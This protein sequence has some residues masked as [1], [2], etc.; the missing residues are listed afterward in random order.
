MLGSRPSDRRRTRRRCRA[1]LVLHRSVERQG[2]AHRRPAAG[3]RSSTRRPLGRRLGRHR[4]GR[5]TD[6]ARRSRHGRARPAQVLAAPVGID[7]DG[8]GRARSRTAPSPSSTSAGTRPAT[9]SRSGSRTRGSLD[10]PAEP[11]PRS[12]RRPAIS[13][14]RTAL[15]R[16]SP[17][18][19]GSRSPTAAWPGRPRPARA[20]RAAGSRSWP[21]PTSCRSGR[22]RSRRRRRRRPLTAPRL[23]R[24]RCAAD[25]AIGRSYGLRRLVRPRRLVVG[26]VLTAA[27]ALVALPGLAGSRAPNPLEPVPAVAFQPLTVPRT[28]AIDGFD[29]S[30]LDDAFVSAADGRRRDTTFD[31][32]PDVAADSRPRSP[33]GRRVTLPA[34][35]PAGRGVRVAQP[36]AG[37]PK[38]SCRR[39][40]LLR[41][42]HDRDAP[43]ARHGRHD[44][45]PAAAASTARRQRLRAAEDEPGRRPVPPGLLRICGCPS[46]SGTTQVTVSVY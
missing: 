33:P 34:R 41:Q 6:T 11:R 13:T 12:T 21:G 9:G 7:T 2:D 35:Q 3:A 23:T 25:C 38:R 19:P 5:P 43:A 31:R 39:R 18:C 17:R 30:R 24:R 22:E 29:R 20:A 40:D 27:L 45:R 8:A 16:T 37:T 28:I 1:A 15:R 32:A 46:W 14:G 10:R 26:S 42:R 36:A 44:L 4:Q